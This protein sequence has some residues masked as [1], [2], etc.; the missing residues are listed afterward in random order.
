MILID[1]IFLD[2]FIFC[3]IAKNLALKRGVKSKAF[4]V[5][6]VLF[7]IG[8]VFQK[9]REKFFWNCTSSWLGLESKGNDWYQVDIDM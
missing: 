6:S 7:V 3:H 8:A 2:T 4:F 5:K 1:S 9:S